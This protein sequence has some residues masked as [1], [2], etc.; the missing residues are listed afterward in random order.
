MVGAVPIYPC[1]L[2]TLAVVG[3]KDAHAARSTPTHM[4]YLSAIGFRLM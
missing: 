1:Q 2:G 3:I 4:G